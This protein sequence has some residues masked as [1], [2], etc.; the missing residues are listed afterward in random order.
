[1]KHTPIG[2]DI[3]NGNIVLNQDA[4]KIQVLF[5]NY[6]GGLSLHESGKE[7]GILKNHAG[8]KRILQN[9]K[10]IG[11]C[12]YPAIIDKGLF[13]KVQSMI[14]NR[15]KQYA[16]RNLSKPKKYYSVRT[17]FSIPRVIKRFD[18]PILQAEYVYSLIAES[19]VENDKYST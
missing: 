7:S 2:Y 10:Y 18:D 1:M 15:A 14:E 3:L 11:E 16:E 4:E 19:E 8:I 13:D 17:S 6:Y 5:S 12:G 9:R